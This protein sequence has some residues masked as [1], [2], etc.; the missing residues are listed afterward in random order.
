MPSSDIFGIYFT[1]EGTPPQIPA[2]HVALYLKDGVL[3]IRDD[4]GDDQEVGTG[5]GSGCDCAEIYTI[6][7]NITASA[8]QEFYLIQ[9]QL[10]SISAAYALKTE[11]AAVSADLQSQIDSISGG[12][13]FTPLN[14][15]GMNIVPTGPDYTFNVVDYISGTEV[16]AISANLQTQIDN[17]SGGG[18]GFTP[19][20]STGM[21]IV[22]TGPD[23]TFS[24]TDYISRT[25]VSNVTGQG[26][27]P[28]AGEGIVVTP[29]GND[30]TFSVDDYISGTEVSS[31][32]GDLQTQIDNISGGFTPLAGTGMIITPTGSDYTFDVADYVSKTE[33]AN[34]TGQLDAT[35]DSLQSQIDAVSGAL[36]SVT[37]AAEGIKGC[38]SVA[39]ATQVISNNGG[40]GVILNFGN[41]IQ[42]DDNYVSDAASDWNF[43]AK[44]TGWHQ[45]S[46]QLGLQTNDGQELFIFIY[47]NGT[48][49]ADIIDTVS[50]QRQNNGG[51]SSWYTVR[52]NQPVF[53]QAGDIIRI[54]ARF[55]AGSSTTGTVGN[56]H[57]SA[58]LDFTS[59][60]VGNV[61]GE[62]PLWKSY[63]VPGVT[64]TNTSVT[65]EYFHIGNKLEIMVHGTLTGSP[66]GGNL[67]FGIPPGFTVITTSGEAPAGEVRLL[68]AGTLTHPGQARFLNGLDLVELDCFID[69]QSTGSLYVA[70][71]AVGTAQPFAWTTG[72]EFWAKIC[73]EVAET[74]YIGSLSNNIGTG[75]AD[76]T[77]NAS[78]IPDVSGAYDLG[79]PDKPWKTGYFTDSSIF[80]GDDKLSTVNGVL[81]VNDQP[82]QGGGGSAQTS[83]STLFFDEFDGATLSQ[84]PNTTAGQFQWAPFQGYIQLTQNVGSAT[85]HVDW[86][87]PITGPYYTILM[88]YFI[89]SNG[90]ADG[91]TVYWGTTGVGSNKGSVVGGYIVECDEFNNQVSL[92]HNGIDLALTGE[93]FVSG[94]NQVVI[95]V[96]N[97][98]IQVW[99]NG[100]QRINYT[101][102]YLGLAGERLGSNAFTGGVSNEHRLNSLSLVQFNTPFGGQI[103]STEEIPTANTW[104]DGKT[105]YR[106]VV[107]LGSGP[108]A[109]TKTAA[110]NISSVDT[111]I[112]VSMTMTNASGVGYTIIQTDVSVGAPENTFVDATDVYWTTIQNRSTYTG[113][114]ILEYTK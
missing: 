91:Q 26:F 12:S 78:I 62:T 98:N 81:Q 67:R 99:V 31:V 73:L 16:A 48:G 72:D 5:A 2:N 108:N 24:V 107:D 110:H 7:A 1:D 113:Y 93:A 36:S 34:V 57:W 6:L 20:A 13:G 106:K 50:S 25:E 82:V 86:L 84:T 71:S 85:G 38:L 49:V 18:S 112:N 105:I 30:Y 65:G 21:T 37:F 56:W 27:T 51:G 80:L 109:T 58:V 45:F 46:G 42:D 41:V 33:V 8:E 66:A 44:R 54:A 17:V 74:A 104:I 63:V 55:A 96:R 70:N 19:L 100:N 77:A 88:N 114:A 4:M 90:G 52:W 111:W 79:S 76:V 95:Y 22:P 23:Y 32:S 35:D 40:D 102:P 92:S 43:E 39:N 68:N 3:R 11:V 87:V 53:L 103:Y 75:T 83:A 9:T 59:V 89:T 94:N 61:G 29:T 10:D 97:D 64:W 69:D 60:N 101:G 47:K 14:G 15:T 28:L